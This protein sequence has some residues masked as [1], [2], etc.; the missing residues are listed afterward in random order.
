MQMWIEP[1]D[2]IALTLIL[3]IEKENRYIIDNE[4]ISRFWETFKTNLK[5]DNITV[6]QFSRKHRDDHHDTF[7][8]YDDKYYIL[9]PWADLKDICHEF[10]GGISTE[11]IKACYKNDSF[12]NLPPRSDED[13][14]KLNQIY[15]NFLNEMEAENTKQYE[16]YNHRKKQIIKQRQR[17]NR[18]KQK[19]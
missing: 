7:Q 17:I 16:F 11:F 9:F 15:Q 13:L 5:Q 18:N 14:E 12:Q 6:I 1:N 19:Q 10:V 8:T 3:T 2:I 4:D